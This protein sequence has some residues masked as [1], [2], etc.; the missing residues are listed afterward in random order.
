MLNQG[1]TPTNQTD[2]GI[3]NPHLLSEYVINTQFDIDVLPAIN[4]NTSIEG[5]PRVLSEDMINNQ[6]DIDVQSISNFQ[7]SIG[8]KSQDITQ[9][10]N[11]N[12]LASNFI[13]FDAH[14]KMPPIANLQPAGLRKS[15]RIAAN[16]VFDNTKKQVIQGLQTNVIQGSQTNGIQGP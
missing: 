5:S 8:K 3:T 4:T 10:D 13:E 2:L 16:Q 12:S 6:Y 11:T 9:D 15:P 1:L 14:S 7:P